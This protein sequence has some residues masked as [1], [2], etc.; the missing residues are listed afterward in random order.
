M[1][2][3]AP[4]VSEYGTGTPSGIPGGSLDQAP[5]QGDIDTIDPDLLRTPGEPKDSNQDPKKDSP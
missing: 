5:I 4:G 1:K 2:R 3:N